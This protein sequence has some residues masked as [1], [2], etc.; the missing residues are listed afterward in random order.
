MAVNTHC[1]TTSGN[2]NL[3]KNVKLEGGWMNGW[4]NSCY[5]YCMPKSFQCWL[6][7]LVAKDCLQMRAF[8]LSLK[9]VLCITAVHGSSS[10]LYD[11]DYSN[12]ETKFSLTHLR[13]CSYSA[14]CWLKDN[15]TIVSKCSIVILKMC[16]LFQLQFET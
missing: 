16:L 9:L 2:A 4:L 13:K 10:Q 15:E 7:H 14:I 1:I 8:L 11:C 6:I 12:L 3:Q 5:K